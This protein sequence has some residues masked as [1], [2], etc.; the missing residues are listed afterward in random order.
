M[1]PGAVYS[2]YCDGGYPP[3]P[4]CNYNG[5]QDAALG[6]TGVDCG[7]GNCPAC[8]SPCGGSPICAGGVC[9]GECVPGYPL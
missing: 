6:E 7:G 1:N 5:V 9:A 3:G 4:V 2:F 8:G